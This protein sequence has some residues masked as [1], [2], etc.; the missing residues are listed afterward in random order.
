MN[1]LVLF[2]GLLLAVSERFGVEC[3]LESITEVLEELLKLL[4]FVFF[5]LG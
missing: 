2:L 4:A 3:V 5:F 1:N